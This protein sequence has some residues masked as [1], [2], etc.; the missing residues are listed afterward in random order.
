MQNM[1]WLEEELGGYEDDYL[2]FDCP[3]AFRFPLSAL[4]DGIPIV[5]V[6]SNRAVHPPP[7]PTSARARAIP[8]WPENL[9]DVSH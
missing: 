5:D 9:C 2:I 3:G 1:D 7:F 4:Q 6:R 8:Y